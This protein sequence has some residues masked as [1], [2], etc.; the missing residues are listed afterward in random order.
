MRTIQVA[1]DK[2]SKY[3][4]IELNSVKHHVVLLEKFARNAALAR[5]GKQQQERSEP[6]GLAGMVGIGELADETPPP[7]VTQSHI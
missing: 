1:S 3:C 5:S 6:V 2:A 4:E 7:P